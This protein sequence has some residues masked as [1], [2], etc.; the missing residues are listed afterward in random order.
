MRGA[1]PQVYLPFG[2]YDPAEEEI[3]KA[4]TFF[5]DWIKILLAYAVLIVL[6]V[7]IC[8]CEKTH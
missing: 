3:R 4:V 5:V 6:L 2:T 7:I 1:P 8:A